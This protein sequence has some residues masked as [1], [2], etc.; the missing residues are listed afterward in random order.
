[1]SG[2]QE[3]F[4]GRIL[5]GFSMAEIITISFFGTSESIT[6]KYAAIGVR[7]TAANLT[8]NLDDSLSIP[9]L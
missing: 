7:N 6:H 1:M 3:V 2:M 4:L 9:K 5:M 8:S